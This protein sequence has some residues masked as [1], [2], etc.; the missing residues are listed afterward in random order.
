MRRANFFHLRMRALAGDG[1]SGGKMTIDKLSEILRAIES[2]LYF[3][4]DNCRI[5]AL[6][7]VPLSQN[8][9]RAQDLLRL[10]AAADSSC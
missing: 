4:T 2:S 9:A 7:R 1:S 5:P 6:C 10:T 3:R 8:A